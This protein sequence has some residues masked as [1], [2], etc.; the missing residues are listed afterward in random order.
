MATEGVKGLKRCLLVSTLSSMTA[1][2]AGVI[3]IFLSALWIT[4]S[5]HY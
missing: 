5:F 3:F 1:W 2:Q 4:Q